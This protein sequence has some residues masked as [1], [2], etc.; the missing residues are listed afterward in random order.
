[1]RLSHLSCVA[2]DVRDSNHRDDGPI[3]ATQDGEWQRDNE[4][5]LNRIRDIPRGLNLGDFHAWRTSL[6]AFA[7]SECAVTA[8]RSDAR[9]PKKH[10]LSVSTR[11]GKFVLVLPC[12]KPALLIIVIALIETSFFVLI[13]ALRWL[14][15]VA[16]GIP[17]WI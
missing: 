15:F 8:E 5:S 13:I 11:I 2:T 10:I 4:H 14:F 12:G 1:M 6:A 16:V 3:A 9:L 7:P 17:K